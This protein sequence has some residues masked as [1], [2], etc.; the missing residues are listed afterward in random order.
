MFTQVTFWDIILFYY[1]SWVY[2]NTHWK[3]KKI[4]RNRKTFVYPS[5]LLVPTKLSFVFLTLSTPKWTPS[6]KWRRSTPSFVDGRPECLLKEFP[7][8]MRGPPLGCLFPKE[9]RH[10]IWRGIEVSRHA[11]AKYWIFHSTIL[12]STGRNRCRAQKFQWME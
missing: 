7:F 4:S 6:Y 1:S 9:T 12:I 8:L 2:P 5:R 10:V 11:V 3:S